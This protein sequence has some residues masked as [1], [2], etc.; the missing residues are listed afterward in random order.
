[1]NPLPADF[2][3]LYRAAFAERDPDKKLVLLSQ[4]QKVVKPWECDEIT[5]A[6]KSNPQAQFSSQK[7]AA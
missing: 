1:M 2:G 4:V 6:G 7:A 3:S 5:A